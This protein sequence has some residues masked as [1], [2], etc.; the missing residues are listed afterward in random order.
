MYVRDS[1]NIFVEMDLENCRNIEIEDINFL[2]DEEEEEEIQVHIGKRYIR[3]GQNPFQ[4]YNELEFKKKVSIF[5]TVSYVRN[6]TINR[7][8]T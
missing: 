4:F 5:E 3:D 1:K 6:I 2:N 7:R 8:Q